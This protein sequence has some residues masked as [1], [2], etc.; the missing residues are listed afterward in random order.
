MPNRNGTSTGFNGTGVLVLAVIGSVATALA[1][2]A[3]P[4]TVP[5][6]RWALLWTAVATFGLAA[7]L[8][9][10]DVAKDWGVAS[11]AFGVWLTLFAALG[12]AVAAFLVLR[13]TPAPAAPPPTPPPNA[14]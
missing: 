4:G 1:T 12:A 5:L 9:F 7:L 14:A 11:K 10:A 3:R 2:L 13:R 8:T 6:S